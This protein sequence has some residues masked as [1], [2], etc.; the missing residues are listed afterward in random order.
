MITAV[1][2]TKTVEK[3]HGRVTTRILTACSLLAESSDWPGLQQVFKVER[4]N[5]TTATGETQTNRRWGHQL[6]RPGGFA[7]TLAQFESKPLGH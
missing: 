3:S 2:T 1:R 5:V 7:G 4:R 6:N